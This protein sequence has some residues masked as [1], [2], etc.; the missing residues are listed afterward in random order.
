LE[1]EVHYST[2]NSLRMNSTLTR[3]NSVHLDPSWLPFK[4]YLFVY[5]RTFQL[6]SVLRFSEQVLYVISLCLIH[7][8]CHTNCRRSGFMSLIIRCTNYEAPFFFFFISL[9]SNYTPY[10]SLFQTPLFRTPLR[11]KVIFFWEFTHLMLPHHSRISRRVLS[12]CSKGFILHKSRACS[13]PHPTPSRGILLFSNSTHCCIQNSRC[14][15]T[16]S[17]R[18]ICFTH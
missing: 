3:M 14:W 18:S 17:V 15:T 1:H 4:F 16:F 9:R 2:H 13:P 10:S 6:V 7:A 5:T 12:P 11:F 8:T